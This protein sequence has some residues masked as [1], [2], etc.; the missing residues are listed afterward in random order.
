MRI[1]RIRALLVA[2]TLAIIVPGGSG[3]A[4]TTP[5]GI[6]IDCG[7]TPM[8]GAPYKDDGMLY[9][10]GSGTCTLSGTLGGPWELRVLVRL[11][12]KIDGAWR[13]R[14]VAISS[15]ENRAAT[16]RIRRLV[17]GH[18]C[19]STVKQQWRARVTVEFRINEKASNLVQAGSENSA[20][21]QR[22]C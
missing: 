19:T 17:V 4:A 3:A 16:K 5:S 8:T 20:V 22:R 11:Q 12:V 14:A 18:A 2:M 9:G 10:S 21:G 6:S 13:T 1:G 15:I 7:A